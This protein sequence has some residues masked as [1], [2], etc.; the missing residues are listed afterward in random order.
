[1]R[2]T[3]VL[4]IAVSLTAFACGSSS[5]DGVPGAGGSGGSGP[6]LSCDDAA[7]RVTASPVL[8]PPTIA[9]GK[10]TGVNIAI[11]VT[12]SAYRVI[13]QMSDADKT[14][15]AALG[16]GDQAYNHARG[17]E[18]VVAVSM[19]DG[20]KPGRYYPDIT[21]QLDPKDGG[22]GDYIH[23]ISNLAVSKTNYTLVAPGE[24]GADS[25]VAMA[26]VTVTP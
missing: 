8:D 4:T 17:C 11:P 25:G 5:S 15:G 24:S 19:H 6:A 23:Y 21:I 3:R 20:V 10:T 22:S 26:Y 12:R 14:V 2:T 7:A 18:V 1:M 9:A 13:V 16:I